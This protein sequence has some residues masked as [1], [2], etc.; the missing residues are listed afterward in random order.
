M[1]S[2]TSINTVLNWSSGKDAALAYHKLSNQSGYKVTQLLTTLSQEYERVFM[3]GTR[4]QLLDL[5]ADRMKLPLKKVKLP[6]SPDDNLYKDAMRTAMQQF[7]SE[8]ITAA[9][10]GDIF[11]EDLKTYREQQ[12]AQINMQA[13]FPLWNMDT[14]SLVAEVEQVG[15]KAIIV[16]V[17]DNHLGKELLGR[18]INAD[19]LQDLPAGVDPCG[20]NGEYHS[21]VYDAPFFHSPIAVKTGEIVHKQYLS[22]NGD[23][24]WDTGFYF[25]DLSL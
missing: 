13:V 20:E 18:E 19:L 4:E 14:R 2:S 23:S 11:L 17:S 24:A 7:A 16:C 25:L 10:F 15:I 1:S 9:A 12:L 21:F 22:A 8:D 3:H 6:A 5:Q